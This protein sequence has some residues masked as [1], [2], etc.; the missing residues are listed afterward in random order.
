M[1]NI[2]KVKDIY[3][4]DTFFIN[5]NYIVSVKPV[6]E[7]EVEYDELNGRSYT[8]RETIQYCNVYMSNGEVYKLRKQ[9]NPEIPWLI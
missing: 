1:I 4:Q 6:T 5:E 7:S 8:V 3:N 9:D 2:K